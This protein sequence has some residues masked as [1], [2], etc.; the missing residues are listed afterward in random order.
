MH[1]VTLEV[2]NESQLELLVS[3]LREHGVEFVEWTE[4][5]E[6]LL[7]ALC[8]RPYRRADLVQPV[9]TAASP[10]DSATTIGDLFK[11]CQL[12]K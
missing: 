11:K 6:N 5:P 7:T 12:F 4:Q 2:K 10:P 8:T 3:R 1:K 9:A